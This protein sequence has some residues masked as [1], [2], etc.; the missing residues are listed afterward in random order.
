M[1][2]Q[3]EEVLCFLC[4][5]LVSPPHPLAHVVRCPTAEKRKCVRPELTRF[6]LPVAG[7]L[8]HGTSS[9]VAD[10]GADADDDA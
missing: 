2:G 7:A 6:L 10:A 5:P 8:G 1:L 4:I 3:I 9:D